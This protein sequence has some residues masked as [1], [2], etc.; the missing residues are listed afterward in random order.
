MGTPPAILERMSYT[1]GAKTMFLKKAVYAA[2]DVG[3][4]RSV[5]AFWIVVIRVSI[6]E[7]NA[8]VWEPQL[9]T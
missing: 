1:S 5:S 3:P 4:E 7:E 2:L 9:Y 6:R 8:G